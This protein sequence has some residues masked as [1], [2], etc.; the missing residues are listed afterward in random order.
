LSFFWYFRFPFPSTKGFSAY[1]TP[2]LAVHGPLIFAAAFAGFLL[3]WPHPILRPLLIVWVLAGVYLGRDLTIL[4]HYN[5]LLTLVSWAVCGV[6][7]F[8]P[9]LLARFGASHIVAPAI[10]S[11]T[12]G[13]TLFFVA[14]AAMREGNRGPS[15]RCRR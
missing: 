5:P 10:A 6:V 1:R 12:V 4:C 11:L 7:L 3:C 8:K 9:G 13:F 15:A 2:G 14:L